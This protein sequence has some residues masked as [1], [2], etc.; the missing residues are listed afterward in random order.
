MGSTAKGQVTETRVQRVLKRYNVSAKKSRGA[1]REVLDL[2]GA[3]SGGWVRGAEGR[4]AGEELP[5]PA[6]D[7]TLEPRLGASG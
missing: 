3:G 4:A 2:P 1:T 7:A 5:E 6:L